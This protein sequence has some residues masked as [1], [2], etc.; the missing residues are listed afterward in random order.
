[1]VTT[2]VDHNGDTYTDSDTSTNFPCQELIESLLY[3]CVETRPDITFAIG[4]ADRFL[5]K[6]ALA[7]VN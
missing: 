2:L 1:M 5:K 4:V 6:L 3:L 7:Y